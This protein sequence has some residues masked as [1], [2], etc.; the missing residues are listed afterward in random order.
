MT[1]SLPPL[2]FQ[3]GIVAEI[4]SYQKVIDG[5]RAVV[6]NYRPHIAI[7]P[8]W[9]LVSI[10]ELANPQYGFTASAQDWGDA[11]FIRITDISEG[12]SLSNKEQKFITLT[13]QSKGSLLER[14]DILV[15]R[16]GATYGKTM[17]F[18]EDYPAVFASYLIRLRFP[19]ERVDPYFYWAFAQSDN[20]W[21]QARALMTGGGQPQFNGNAIK[22]VKLPLPPLTTQ[23]AIAAELEAE[24][25]IIE[26]N[27]NLIQRFELKVQSAVASVWGSD[28]PLVADA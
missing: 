2:E 24:Q 28:A 25:T 8:E 11:R 23:Q 13:S 12:G 19:P 17:L 26:S 5:A 9:P 14:G 7:D 10:E 27:R 3:A 22:Q 21:N 16:T 4:E 18:D 6:D 15:A 20:Y 1:I